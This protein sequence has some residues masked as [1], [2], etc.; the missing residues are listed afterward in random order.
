MAIT[1]DGMVTSPVP[2]NGWPLINRV[3]CKRVADVAI[4]LRFAAIVFAEKFPWASLET[5][6]PPTFMLAAF[7]ET[8]TDDPVNVVLRPLDP[9]M[10][11]T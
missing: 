10:A 7:E 8:T 2:S 6:A 11:D 1:V 4:P 9:E 5:I 3:V